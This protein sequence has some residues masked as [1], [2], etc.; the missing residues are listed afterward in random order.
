MR[1]KMPAYEIVAAGDLNSYVEPFTKDFS[2]FPAS[3]TDMTTVKKRTYTQGQY[4]K[5]DKI[6]R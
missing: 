2:F 3:N 6:I 5:A 1:A 4:N